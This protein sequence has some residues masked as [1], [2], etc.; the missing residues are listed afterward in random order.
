L[1]ILAILVLS[2]CAPART[3]TLALLGD[4]NLGRA[5]APTADSLSYLA[6]EL[7]A[8]DLALATL[9]SPLTAGDFPAAPPQGYDLCAPAEQASLLAEWGLDLLALENNH[10]SDCGADGIA[11]SQ[12]AL[13]AAGLAGLTAA[14]NFLEINGLRLAFL[15]FDDVSAP[16]DGDAASQA[17]ADAAGGGAL[18]VVSVHWGA[19]YQVGPTARQQTLAR[20]F[21]DAG[22]ALVVGTHPHVLQ[23]AEWIENARGKTLVLYSLGNA[24]FDQTGLD[25]TRQSALVV[26]TLDGRGVTGA[27]AVPFVIDIRH[28]RLIAPDA[29]AAEKILE[30][31]HLP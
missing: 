28:S 26:A 4:I 23:R 19:E 2:S 7:S 24:L 13:T 21:A 1:L 3:V 14:P 15:A 31:L 30:R 20:Q 9:E 18:V 6:S 25:D 22:A 10:A 29:Q 8:A 12:A 5:V 11:Q 16:L 27:R 17:I